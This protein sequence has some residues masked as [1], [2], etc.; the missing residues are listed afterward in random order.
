LD[1][2]AKPVELNTPVI[3]EDD[4]SLRLADSICFCLVFVWFLSGFCLVS[5]WFLSGFCLVFSWAAIGSGGTAV[6]PG[7]TASGL[8]L[9]PAG[10]RLLP[11]RTASGLQLLPGRTAAAAMFSVCPP[12]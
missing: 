12:N 4:W 8:Q 11:D 6:A 3:K 1:E 2:P 9:L 5:V 10:L 7:E